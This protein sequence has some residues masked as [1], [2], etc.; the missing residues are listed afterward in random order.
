EIANF[1]T[2]ELQNT[3]DD[4]IEAMHTFDGIGLAAPQIG[5]Q[6]RLIAYGVKDNPRYPHIK[7]ISE[8]ILINPVYTNIGNQKC[9]A[10]ERC[11]SIP[12]MRGRVK[13]YTK[14]K[15]QGYDF[16]GNLIEMI[17]TDF[18]A[19]ILQ[20]EI[21]HLDGILYPMRID[22]LQDFGY[23]EEITARFTN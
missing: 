23:D 6:K 1:N 14:I 12:G 18:F 2:I 19:R 11:L 5:I 10:L 13:R 21:D 15:I 4:L 8:G 17:V 22:N 16:Q 3:I 20:H 9:Y 7:N